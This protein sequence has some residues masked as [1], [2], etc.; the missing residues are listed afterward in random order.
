MNNETNQNGFENTIERFEQEFVNGN[1]PAIEEY[2]SSSGDDLLLP[3]L[4]HTELELRL[5]SGEQARVENYTRR[6]PSLA[7]DEKL[8]RDLVLTEYNVR[9]NFDPGCRL[10]EYLLRFPNLKQLLVD[11]FLGSSIS[12]DSR[13]DA[14]GKESVKI[15]QDSYSDMTA[16]FRK[17]SLHE[18]GGLGNVWLARDVELNRDVAVKE[19]KSK[20][21]N[22]ESHQA[23]FDRE[24]MITGRLEH[25]GIVPVY[26]QG[27]TGIGTPFFAMQFV[28]GENLKTCINRFHAHLSRQDDGNAIAFNRLIQHFI[29]VCHTVEFAH[30]QNVVHRDIKPENIMIGQ[31]GETFLIDWGLAST[32][33][34]EDPEWED[35][36]LTNGEDPVT[37]KAGQTIGSPAFMSPEQARGELSVI[38]PTSDIYSLGATL[39]SLITNSNNPNQVF[40]GSLGNRVDEFRRQLRP[41]LNPLLSVCVRAMAQSPDQRYASVQQLREDVENYLLDK[42]LVAHSD[43]I[44]ERWSR[45]LRRNRR[46]LNTAV[47][48]LL[49]ISILSGLAAFWINSERNEAI[50]ARQSETGLRQQAQLMQRQEKDARNRSEQRT[51]QLTRVIGIFVDALTGSDDAGLDVKPNN[52]T[53]DKII[54]RLR[55][56]IGE[57]EE[58]FARALLNAV[59]ARGEKVAGNY[60]DSI[61]HYRDAIE[62]L[63][64][65][66]IAECDPLHADFLLGLCSTQLADGKLVEAQEMSNL[67]RRVCDQYPEQLVSAHFRVLLCQA[68]LASRRNDFEDALKLATQADEI[69]RNEYPAGHANVMWT[70]YEL[71]SLHRR[72]EDVESAIPLFERIVNDRSF[73]GRGH[74]L[75]IAAA[76]QLAELRSNL[77]NGDAIDVMEKANLDAVAIFGEDHPESLKVKARLG[78]FLAKQ[79]DS[80]QQNRGIRLLSECRASQ[81]ELLGK[82]DDG[83]LGTTQLLADSLLRIE[84]DD[85]THRALDLLQDTIDSLN[86]TKTQGDRDDAFMAV[87]Y[88]RLSLAF[89]RLNR[90]AQ[91]LEARDQSVVKAIEAF[92]NESAITKRL[93]EKRNKLNK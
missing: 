64:Q 51:R 73:S 81:I 5:T 40:S 35:A 53:A 86:S 9:R 30:S 2:V 70:A 17:R 72:L 84:S 44:L 1:S 11:D 43:T 49:L 54:E 93:I 66:K 48:S 75:S 74:P 46:V 14:S 4:V 3:E 22:S 63:K 6:F 59:V 47:V 87:F 36:E 56:Q 10:E 80:N 16:R 82:T 57:N 76:I 33:F 60:K 13:S 55:S 34:V 19:I 61:G 8:V 69:C 12:G 65:E 23:R 92:G 37:S 62:L 28:Q 20:F 7:E 45:F 89:Q 79:T 27:K 26:G 67:V 91:A 32:P 29:D 42:P 25:P 15:R 77:G 21:A 90:T 88:D 68:K 58:P 38:G 52:L 18:Q 71:A 50:I 83:V 24:T 41:E 39:F 85:A 31:Y 78:N